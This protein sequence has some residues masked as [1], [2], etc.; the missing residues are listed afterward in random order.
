[1]SGLLNFFKN[2]FSGIFGFIG[3]LF[4]GKSKDGF[5][6]ELK[7]EAGA[8]VKTAATVAAVP[9]PATTPVVESIPATPSTGKSTRAEKLAVLA[10]AGQSNG[11]APVA[12][13]PAVATALNLPA[14]VVTAA[15][16]EPEVKTFAD[17]YLM[18]V[19]TPS[20]RPGANMS[21]FLTMA[22]QVSK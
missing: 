22:R 1:M 18:P 19:S 20:R 16:K 13:A 3:G 9:T 6:L 11:S 10:A 12:A 7:D 5:Y 15:S 14:P 2:L 17:K 4:G 21:S 8:P